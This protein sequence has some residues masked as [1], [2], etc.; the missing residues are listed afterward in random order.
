MARRK[1]ITPNTKVGMESTARSVQHCCKKVKLEL[2]EQGQEY[3][4]MEN[5]LDELKRMAEDRRPSGTPCR[6]DWGP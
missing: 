2:S 6:D 1:L 5:K 3:V 4:E